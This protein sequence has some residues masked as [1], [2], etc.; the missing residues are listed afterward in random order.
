MTEP[1][2]NRSGGGP[3]LYETAMLRRHVML[4]QHQ[5]EWLDREAERRDVSVA[6]LIRDAID[7]MMSNTKDQPE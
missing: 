4:P 5:V 3:T 1:K 7:R 2:K 6:T